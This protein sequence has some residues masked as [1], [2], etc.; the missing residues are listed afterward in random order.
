MK[1]SFYTLAGI[2]TAHVG[3]TWDDVWAGW[4]HVSTQRRVVRWQ[5]L[6]SG[7]ERL[8]HIYQCALVTEVGKRSP[9]PLPNIF[10]R[11]LFP[12]N[13]FLFFT[14]V[15]PRYLSSLICTRFL[16]CYSFNQLCFFTFK[17]IVQVTIFLWLEKYC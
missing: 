12:G 5:C 3:Q 2:P 14:W 8:N 6:M 16:F 10:C 15:C 4:R 17:R 1:D 13:R 7:V 11:P 9:A